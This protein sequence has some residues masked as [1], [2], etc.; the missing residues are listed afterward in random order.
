M[1][2][3]SNQSKGNV[4]RDRRDENFTR[5]RPKLKDFKRRGLEQKESE[6]GTE[7]ERK[8]SI[9]YNSP[10][11]RMDDIFD[12]FRTGIEDMMM[13]PW[14]YSSPSSL[15]DWRFPSLFRGGREQEQDIMA[16]API[17]DIVDKGEKYELQAELPGIDKDKVNVKA[18]KDSIEIS[19]EQSEEERTQDK[20][21]KYV[22][23]ERSYT[24][25]Y[26]SIPFPEEIVSSKVSAT[27]N[28]GILRIDIP[29]K[30]PAT[31]EE[32]TRVKIE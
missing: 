12:S 6:K 3:R 17:F 26:R 31:D 5:Y 21:K 15:Y 29:K 9:V 14:S 22:Y 10:R 1:T 2:P 19:S 20:R 11:R 16:R 24:S 4:R 28:N 13:T 32:V 25:F 30:N 23:N 27:I 7:V 18:T 8:R